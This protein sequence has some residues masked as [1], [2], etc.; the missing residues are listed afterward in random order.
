MMKASVTTNH[1]FQGSQIKCIIF[2]TDRAGGSFDTREMLYTASTRAEEK[3]IYICSKLSLK[4]MFG[5]KETH[6][7]TGMKDMLHANLERYKN[8]FSLENIDQAFPL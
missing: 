2:V 7:T 4:W 6:R 3:V 5:N 1:G 8:Y